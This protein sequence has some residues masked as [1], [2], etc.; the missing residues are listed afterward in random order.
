[1]GTDD[2][3]YEQLDSFTDF[4]GIVDLDQ[5]TPLP[6]DWTVLI[7]DVVQSTRAIEAGKYKS[8]NMVGAATIIC[9]LNIAEDLPLPF[10]FGGDGGMIAVPPTLLD[11]ARAELM[12]L[13]TSCEALFG[14]SLRASA[15]PVSALSDAGA[16]ISV[17]KYEL[18]PGNHLAMFAGEGPALADIWLKSEAE[19]A[20]FA[21]RPEAGAEAPNLEGLSCR[22]EPLKS[23]HGTM[24]TVIAV[25]QVGAAAQEIAKVTR[26]LNQVAG[27]PVS[28]LAPARDATMR[29]RFPPRGLPL[30]LAAGDKSV[31]YL[32]RWCWAVFTSAMQ[33]LCER[34]ALK[35]GDYDGASYRA[36]LQS[37]TDFRKFDG[38]LRMVLD[39]S[40]DQADAIEAYLEQEFQ[41][42]RLVYGTWRSATAL[43]TCLLFDLK[44][45]RHLHF[46]DGS[47]GGYALAA[48]AMKQRIA[49]PT[50]ER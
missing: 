35:I 44:D 31:P 41:A 1:M 15:I 37:H 33:Y 46:I 14:L 19:G 29:F 47:D 38:A 48:Q 27:A 30:E 4:S 13:Q 42:G 3:F 21:L 10:V 32:R 43:M 8:V 23:A 7:S 22:W 39:V 20:A 49:P 40:R 34:F 17:R 11:A 16:E 26:H 6:R 5:Y 45:S 25:P 18:S 24:L 9:V 12:K 36:E 50:A 28:S 2:R